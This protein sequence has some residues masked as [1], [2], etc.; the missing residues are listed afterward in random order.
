MRSSGSAPI[1]DSIAI[2]FRAAVP[3]DVAGR[4]GDLSMWAAQALKEWHDFYMLVGT[5]GATLL[6][7]LFVAVS[8]GAGYLTE[9]RQSSTRTFM[10]PVV[11]HFTSV[12]F[13]SAV[14]LFPSHQAKFFAAII[15][16]TALIGAIVSTY[17]TIQVVRSDMTSY[18]EDYLAY[19]LLPGLGYLSLLAAAVS[20]YLERDFGLNALAGALL[21]LAIVNIRNAWDLML[22]MARRHRRED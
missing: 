8:L 11:I 4:H 22:A 12:F 6:G 16:A 18:I 3:Y 20:I 1:T 21:L 19:G 9:E 17:I 5:A 15:G 13:L 2:G 7:L 14:A 10:S